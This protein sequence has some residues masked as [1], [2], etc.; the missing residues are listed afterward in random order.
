ME[1]RG[2]RNKNPFNIRISDNAWI[3]K[4]YPS[5]DSKFEQFFSLVYGIRAGLVLLKNYI[6]N[7]HCNTARKIISRFAPAQENDL[8]SYLFF[9]STY[10]DLDKE[11]RFGSPDFVLL[12]KAILLYESNY[13]VS[14]AYINQLIYQFRLS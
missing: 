2:L 11:I 13:S 7:F 3:G 14:A 5:S 1:T 12:V 9:V 8:S 10:L 4:K 6:N